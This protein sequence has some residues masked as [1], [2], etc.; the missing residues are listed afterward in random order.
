MTKTINQRVEE[1]EDKFIH[2]LSDVN[3][4]QDWIRTTLQQHED[5]IRSEYAKKVELLENRIEELHQEISE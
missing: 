2:G 3:V 4:L 5:Q 1:F